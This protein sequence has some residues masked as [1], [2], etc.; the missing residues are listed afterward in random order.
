[1]DGWMGTKC[2]FVANA[3]SIGLEF[4]RTI[5]WT[6]VLQV[7]CAWIRLC[8]SLPADSYGAANL[9]VYLISSSRATIKNTNELGQ[10]SSILVQSLKYYNLLSLLIKTSGLVVATF[11][12]KLIYSSKGILYRHLVKKRETSKESDLFI[13]I[14]QG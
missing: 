2:A 3:Y 13:K 12:Q 6:Y 11:I 14:I 1:M 9:A 10:K 7:R 4:Y 5:T 8:D